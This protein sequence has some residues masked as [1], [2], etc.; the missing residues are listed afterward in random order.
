MVCQHIPSG[1]YYLF[2]WAEPSTE[3]QEGQDRFYGDYEPVE[4]VKQPLITTEWMYVGFSAR[5]G[6]VNFLRDVSDG[7]FT[8]N[9]GPQVI[10]DYIT[11]NL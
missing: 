4:V 5:V 6:T 10:A 11:E 2:T 9:V 7:V 3:S 8:S 1:K